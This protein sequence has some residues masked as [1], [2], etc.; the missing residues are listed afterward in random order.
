M[1]TLVKADGTHIE[2]KPTGDTF[3]LKELQEAV[4]GYIEIIHIDK[5]YDM[6]VNEEG[7]LYQ[8][9]INDVATRIFQRTRYTQDY[10]VGNVLICNKNQLQ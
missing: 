8:L 2:Y 1:A 6:V 9:P 7:K 3:T 4:G 10:I 5:E